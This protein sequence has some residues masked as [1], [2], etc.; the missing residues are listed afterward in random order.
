[1]SEISLGLDVGTNSIGWAL[2]NKDNDIVKVK[3]FSM[4]GVRMFD[5]S[6]SS[7]DRRGYRNSRRRLKRRRER[8][9]YLQDIF[10]EEINK[11]DKNFFQRLNDSFFK[12]EDKLLEN[13]YTFFDDDIT[14][15]DYFERF[16]TIYHLRKYLLENDEK[17]DIR[18]L[19]LALHHIIKYRG[20]FLYEGSFSNSNFSIVKKDFEYINEVLI[21]KAQE[22]EDDED[23]FCEINLSDDLYYKLN[24]ILTSKKTKNDKKIELFNYLQPEKKSI[25]NELIIPLLVGGKVSVNNLSLIKD[26]KYE[27][28]EIYLDSDELESK[29]NE[30][31]E[32]IKELANIFDLINNI[33]EIYD[34]YFICKLIGSSKYLSEAMV[35]KY[36]KHQRDL[37]LLKDLIHNNIPSMYN[38]MFRNCDKKIPNYPSYIG[39]NLTKTRKRFEHC[40][41]DNFYAYVKK[42]LEKINNPECKTCIDNIFYEIENEDFLPRQNSGNNTAI[43]MQLNYTELEKI[44]ETQAKY[45]PFLTEQNDKYSPIDKIKMIFKYRIPY[46]V[47]PLAYHNEEDNTGTNRAWYKRKPGME[48]QKI[49]PWTFNDVVD[50][51][52]SAK[53]F[54]QRMQNKCSYLHGY[55]DYCLP[56]KSLLYSEYNCLQ[57]LNKLQINGSLITK[58]VKMNLFE[59][60]FLKK[61]KPTKKDIYNF[62]ESHYGFDSSSLNSKIDNIPCDMSSYIK[63]KEI[64]GDEF[65]NNKDK[66]EEII[67]DITIFED[68][69]ILEKRLIEVY[70]LSEDKVKQIKDL[71]YKGYGRLC[72]KLLNGLTTTNSLTGEAN[73]TIIDILRDTNMN[74]MDVLASQEY[75]FQDIID[76]YNKELL[77]ENKETV[78]EYIKENLFVSADG[79]RAL[80]QSY[81]LIEEVERII[82]RPID[83]YYI[84]C[85]R[86]NQQKKEETVSRKNKTLELLKE[87]KKDAKELAAFN[88][89]INKL[90]EDLEERDDQLRG[91]KL[92]LYYMQLGRCMYTF[93]K[94][95]INDLDKYDIDHIYPQ[96]LIKDD[97]FNNKVLVSKTFNQNKKKDKFLFEV[98]NRDTNIFGFYKF[99]LERNLI[100][101]EKYRRLTETEITK[102]KLDGFVNRQL[103]STNQAV[104]GLITLLKE[105]KGVDPNN[106]IYSKAENISDF[107]RDYNFEKSRE[108]NNFH[109]AHDAYLNAVVGGAIDKYYKHHHLYYYDDYENLKKENKT[110][111]PQ[112]I[113]KYS[114]IYD[115]NGGKEVIWDKEATLKKI[116]YYLKQ[117]YDISETQRTFEGSDMYGKVTIR[118]A[119][120]TRVPV[121]LSDARI[122]VEKYGGIESNAYPYFSIIKAVDKKGNVNYILEAIPYRYKDNKEKYIDETYKGKYSQY[123]V[124]CDKIKTKVLV[125]YGKTAF[126]ITGKTGNAFLIMNAIDRYISYDSI[127]AIKSITKYNDNLKF[128]N[129][130]DESDDEIILAKDKD[131]NIS[132]KITNEECTN[133][134]NEIITVFSKDIYDY[135]NIKNVIDTYNSFDKQLT[136][137]EKINLSYQLIQ[138]L[139]TNS[140]TSADLSIINGSKF[141]GTIQINKKLKPKMKFIATSITGYYEKLLF[142]VPDV[143]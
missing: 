21:E 114:R 100:T 9:N 121:S 83:K 16:P 78:E 51:D 92:F 89:D 1:M 99:L 61:K 39:M 96:S 129:K 62:L 82:G 13:H 56:K 69:K 98:S 116:N 28:V 126:Y 94:I 63:F 113:L 120:S 67:K 108:A 10:S 135:S 20:N 22:Y 52:E 11:V 48:N 103:V 112:T 29:T 46:Y 4:W 77:K 111:N 70:E 23:Y 50:T 32:K 115:K 97:S 74:L 107:R 65:E 134:L 6:K 18:M 90:I 30:A 40:T 133:L 68:K 36:E 57:Y 143:L 59:N 93:S 141:S 24:E 25:V 132:R 37:K 128:K 102:D 117:K 95:E 49:Y 84:E 5:E 80:N 106:I 47:G 76:N 71:N 119:S 12:T 140:R 33:K 41:Q 43:P 101:K 19:Y 110:I 105:Y 55:D 86:S 125:R 109:H 72:K 73:L 127:K 44:L 27:K 17:I 60:V 35:N 118:P 79:T 85:S 7:M 42:A 38:E 3:N 104:K 131:G 137:K 53:E 91:E 2:I 130:M 14:D 58:D 15:R 64:F 54:I 88:I 26:E 81:K 75:R 31:K 34:F 87:A 142:E 139:K 136:L 66:I 45:Y 124:V 8:I 138:L 122:D 123:E